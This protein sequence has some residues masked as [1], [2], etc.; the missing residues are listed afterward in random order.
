MPRSWPD[1]PEEGLREKRT[2]QQATLVARKKASA[3]SGG[4]AASVP[5]PAPKTYDQMTPEELDAEMEK[6]FGRR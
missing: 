2:T 6:E 5:R 1:Q 3:V 4:S